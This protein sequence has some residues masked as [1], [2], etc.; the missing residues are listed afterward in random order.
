MPHGSIKLIPGVNVN[1][2][3]ALNEAGFSTSN[4]IRF[5]YDKAH[6]A[7]VQKLGG[8][9]QYNGLAT[10]AI[11]RAML[12]WEDTNASKHLAYATENA[13]STGVAQLNVYPP[14]NGQSAITPRNL[15]DSITV[16]VSTT[17]GSNI[18]TINDATTTGLTNYDS[19]YIAT[20]ISVG[21]LVLF[22][23]YAVDPDGFI[24]A[25]SY[26]I[27]ATD[28]LGNPLPATSTV[29]NGGAVPQ[30]VTTSG[31]TSV[32]VNLNNHGYAVGSTFPV[33]VSTTVGGVVFYGQYI[34]QSVTNANSFVISATYTPSSS[35][36]VSMNGGNAYYLYN[37]GVGSIPTGTGYGVGT[38]GGGGY[39]T[40]TAVVPSTGTP[41]SA[42]DW[43]LDNW[44]EVLLACPINAS[45][46]P[47]Y[48]PIYQWDPLSGSPTA[49]VIP[50]APPVN[51]GFFVAMP[52]RQII[53]WGSTFTGIQDPLLIRWCDVNNYNTWIGQ[54]TNQAGSYR[55]PK[56]S[57]IVGCIQGPQQGLIWTDI[58]VWS[59]QYI[60]TP[61]IYSFNEVG[62]GCGLIARKA[63]ASLNGVVYWMGPSNFYM[64]AGD[65]VQYVPCPIWDTIFQ[66]LDMAH[67]S[68]VRVAVNSRF[69]EIT[70]YYPSIADG[71]EVNAY[72]KLN[73]ALGTWDY[74]NI[75]RSAW[76]D[77]SVLGPPIGADANPTGSSYLIYQH[78]SSAS[79]T[80]YFDANGQ[81]MPTSFT[82]GYTAIS[83]G[84][85]L[86]Y[87]DQVWPDMR[88]G[89][90]GGSQNATVNL[91]FNV[92]NYP[93]DTPVTYGPYPVTQTTEFISPRFRGRLVSVT[94]SG[95][96]VGTFWRLGN[97]RYRFQPDGKF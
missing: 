74:G 69:S 7:L 16:S 75:G 56:G 12:G 67:L 15:S 93:G 22:G 8:W 33:L 61:Y 46:V 52:Q 31:S 80:P 70:W 40:G 3:P 29:S 21:G 82:T 97:I 13:P 41:I 86:M 81:A 53:A 14:V 37:F 73:A 28:L 36:T 58:G 26:T 89:F 18:V 42:T 57:A 30:F 72:A 35:A 71:G 27:Y 39:G 87:V 44:G 76:I 83:D 91:T 66:D 85:M 4:L 6:G 11:V 10:T 43:T 78:E 19:V 60:S 48:Q 23:Q 65:G 24:G 92:A 95:N 88:W 90:Y 64:L 55:I 77:Q 38:Y 63:A 59:M 5:I 25:T 54:I 49:T 62:S 94:L 34:V 17:A 84:D 68:K 50:N 32:T 79:G 45:A 51:D 96:D 20:Q 1:S 9:A 47:Q 2:T